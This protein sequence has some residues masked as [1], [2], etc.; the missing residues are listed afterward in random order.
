[1]KKPEQAVAVGGFAAV[2]SELH[3]RRVLHIHHQFR[4]LKLNRESD[5]MRLHYLFPV[6]HLMPCVP[7][8]GA[9]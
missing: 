9:E 2:G 3:E 7:W 8:R 4:T 5:E 1:M 6:L